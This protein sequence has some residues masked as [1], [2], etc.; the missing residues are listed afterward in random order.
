MRKLHSALGALAAAALILPSPSLA[1]DEG[2]GEDAGLA[3][4][5]SIEVAPGDRDAYETA[6]GQLVDAAKLADLDAAAW[7]WF[8]W[9]SPSGYTLVYPFA[10]MAYWDD[11]GLWQRQFAGTPGEAAMAE[12]FQAF[13]TVPHQATSEILEFVPEWMYMPGGES[14]GEGAEPELKVAHVHDEWVRSGQEE[15]YD[16]LSKDFIAF[17]KDI[18]YPYMVHGHRTRIG[19][20]RMVWVVFADELAGYYSDDNWMGLIEEHGASE[21]WQELDARFNDL[22]ARWDHS[23][24]T[25]KADMSY[26][27]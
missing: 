17:L 13:G 11:E 10:N 9:S 23:D 21:R 6:V 19:P 18:E 3:Y 22:V 2:S 25:Y 1:Q 4:I 7:G 24:Y 14:A 12:A 8:F 16:A 15:A 27:P 26:R 20:Q 5:V